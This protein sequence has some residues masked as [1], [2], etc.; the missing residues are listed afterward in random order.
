MTLKSSSNETLAVLEESFNAWSDDRATLMAAA[1]AYYTLFSVAPLVIIATAVA[2]L[3]F[4]QEASSHEIFGSLRGL[5]GDSGAHA[6][7]GMVQSSSAQPDGS[8]VAVVIGVVVLVLGAAGVF[9]QLQESLNIIWKVRALPGGGIVRLLRRRLLTFAMVLSIG[10]LLLV[11]LLVSAALSATGQFLSDNLPGG[12]VLWQVLNTCVSLG[13]ITALFALIFKV[14]PDVKL[15]WREVGLG[16]FATALLFSAGK[17]VIG[18]YLGKSAVASG[19]GAAGSLVIILVWVFYTS[20]ILLFGAELTRVYTLRY[21]RQEIA[22]KHGAELA[23]TERT[24]EAPPK[25]VA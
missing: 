13:V 11:S 25:R 3:V 15:R 1:I 17:L 23:E 12:A 9:N 2:G 4:G 6:I 18:L 21:H 14:L 5:L 24:P 22:P 16:A 20:L 8:I 7:E 19:F 10:F